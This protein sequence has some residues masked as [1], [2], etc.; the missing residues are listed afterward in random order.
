VIPSFVIPPSGVTIFLYLSNILSFDF[1]EE[2]KIAIFGKSTALKPLAQSF[3]H[4]KP[5][6][7]DNILG[8]KSSI[9]REK[10]RA[11]SQV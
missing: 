9:I 3:V 10:N 11:F 8:R 4:M 2:K 5:K 6:V 7:M 1:S